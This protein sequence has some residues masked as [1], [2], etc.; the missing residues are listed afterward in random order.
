MTTK[1]TRVHVDSLRSDGMFWASL[2]IW[3]QTVQ[4]G[5]EDAVR[6]LDRI[7]DPATNLYF[8]DLNASSPMGFRIQTL[9]KSFD[10]RQTQ[11]EELGAYPDRRYAETV[12]A[13][14]LVPF[15]AEAQPTFRRIMTPIQNRFA[16]YEAI[17]LP[18]FDKLGRVALSVSRLKL[19]AEDMDLPARPVLS[20]RERDCLRHLAAGRSAKQ[21]AGLLELSSRTVE[22]HIEAL[23]N[24]LGARNASHAVAKEMIASLDSRNS[25]HLSPPT[26]SLSPRERQCL[27]LIV[28]GRSSRYMAGELEISAKTVEKH[29]T[30]LRGKLGARNMTELTAKGIL[31]LNAAFDEAA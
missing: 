31:A 11:G 21:I 7:C 26:A 25:S 15:I 18:Y 12:L 27:G 3:G 30:S 4:G 5:V 14:N 8:I 19:L 23:K 29:I 6:A 20:P 9:R 22:H 2:G 16:I 10:F 24:K 17:W 1:I 13:S 28:S